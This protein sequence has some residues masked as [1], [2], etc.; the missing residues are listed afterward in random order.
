M[1]FLSKFFHRTIDFLPIVQCFTQLVVAFCGKFVVFAGR[2]GF[3]FFPLV[4]EHAFATHF[5]EQGIKRAFLGGEL[6]GVELFQD[7]GGVDFLCSD[8]LEYKELQEA[9][10]DGREFFVDAH[11]LYDRK[12][13]FY[14]K[15][16][17]FKKLSRLG[18]N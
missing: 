7:V 14:I 9:L 3:R 8:N 11:G 5:T 12:L 10:P 17:G 6:G 4:V 1:L 16:A 15:V 13:P 2:A 18:Y